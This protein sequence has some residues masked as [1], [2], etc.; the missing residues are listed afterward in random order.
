MPG[1]WSTQVVPPSVVAMTSPDSSAPLSG[2]PKPTA[3][4]SRFDTHETPLRAIAPAGANWKPHVEPPSVVAAIIGGVDAVPEG[5]EA[6]ATQSSA[7]EHEI[8]FATTG[9]STE[10]AQVSPPSVLTKT[11]GP[12]DVANPTA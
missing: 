12:N 6:T 10:S 7:D 9:S 1:V 8:P 4:Q 5:E 2:L 3:T 11:V